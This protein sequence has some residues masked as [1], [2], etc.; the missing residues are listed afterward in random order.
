MINVWN[1][2]ESE[3]VFSCSNMLML[4]VSSAPPMTF[5]LR[6]LPV[7]AL[8]ESF[9]GW[10]HHNNEGHPDLKVP[11]NVSFFF[12]GT[13]SI[14]C[15]LSSES[16]CAGSSGSFGSIYSSQ[17]PKKRPRVCQEQVSVWV[18]WDDDPDWNETGSSVSLF[19]ST[20]NRTCQHPHSRMALICRE[21]IVSCLFSS[22]MVHTEER[23][24]D[25]S[26]ETS[27][28]LTHSTTHC[29]TFWCHHVTTSLLLF[30]P[31]KKNK[32]KMTF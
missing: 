3:S 17:H 16:L 28:L 6:S 9:K 25:T 4:S 12:S 10:W 29:P 13:W 31:L 5:R 19:V 8:T 15:V 26:V 7:T 32:D 20:V 30:A 27:V 2:E 14:R 23:S 18:Q 21:P 22:M 11:T 24:S 1:Q